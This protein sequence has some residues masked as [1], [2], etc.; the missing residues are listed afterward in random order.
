MSDWW[1]IALGVLGGLAVLWVGLVVLLWAEARRHGSP[2]EL[3]AALRLVPDVIRLVKRLATDRAVPV[4]TRIWLGALLV[5]LLTPID[6][7]PDVVPVLG[8]VDDAIVVV[9]VLR[10]AIRHTGY[11]PVRRH[12]PGTPEGLAA[13]LR[14]TGLEPPAPEG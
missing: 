13:L 1:Q 12:W 9:I 14:L 5:Y 6:L 2:A 11:G 8:L 10:A 7:I 4:G 3:R